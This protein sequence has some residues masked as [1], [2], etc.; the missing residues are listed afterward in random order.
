MTRPP[1][2][3]TSSTPRRCWKALRLGQ[4]TDVL[5]PGLAL[6]DHPRRPADRP[7]GTGV[8]EGGLRSAHAGTSLGHRRAEPPGACPRSCAAFPRPLMMSGSGGMSWEGFRRS[9]CVA[10]S[11][12]D[13]GQIAGLPMRISLEALHDSLERGDHVNGELNIEGMAVYGESLAPANAV[14]RWTRTRTGAEPAD[15]PGSRR[16]ARVDLDDLSVG[17]LGL[18][19]VDSYDLGTC[20]PSMRRYV[21]GE[22]GFHRPRRDHR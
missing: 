17:V 20:R 15:R 16:S 12:D 11:L 4:D 9:T 7:Q 3:S 8:Q 13:E 21:R 18:R 14:T 2:P 22:A 1:S 6:E 19:G 5:R 10:Y